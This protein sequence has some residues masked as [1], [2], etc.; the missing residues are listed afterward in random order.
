MKKSEPRFSFEKNP[1]ANHF[2]LIE[3][4]IGYNKNYKEAISYLYTKDKQ[5]EVLKHLNNVIFFRLS[6]ERKSLM[7]SVINYRFNKIRSYL[8]K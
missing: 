8:N 7:E 1:K 5:E 2:Q 4:L 6:L 3:F